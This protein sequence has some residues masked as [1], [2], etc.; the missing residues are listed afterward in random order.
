L[1]KHP[2]YKKKMAVMH[3]VPLPTTRVVPPW[4]TT[5]PNLIKGLV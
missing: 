3:P 4:Y 1:A 2:K 5:I